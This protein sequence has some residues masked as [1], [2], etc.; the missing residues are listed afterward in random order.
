MASDTNRSSGGR[1]EEI[2]RLRRLVKELLENQDRLER[3]IHDLKRRIGSREPVPV[4]LGAEETS[5]F[6]INGQIEGPS[7]ALPDSKHGLEDLS[8]FRSLFRGREDVF[9]RMWRNAKGRTGYSPACNNEWVEGLCRKGEVKCADCPHRELTPLTD[10]VLLDHLRGKQVIGVYPLLPSGE[11]FFLA[12]D[13]D[14]A[15]WQED[16]S[17]FLAACGEHGIVPAV[18]RSRSGEGGHVWIFFE[19]AV[20]AVKARR[21]GSLLLTEAMSR[22]YEISMSTYDRF[23]PNQ[24]LMPKGGFG[25]LIALPLQRTSLVKGNT[26]FLDNS[27]KPFPDQWRYLGSISRVGRQALDDLAGELTG[28]SKSMGVCSRFAE[29]KDKPWLTVPSK[30]FLPPPLK[31]PLPK[32]VKATLGN[33]VYVEKEG[34]PASLL[35]RIRRLAA[36]QNPEFYKKQNLRLST[37]LTPRM[38]CCAEDFPDHV[39]I[40]R[41]CLGDLQLLLTGAGIQLSIKD[42]RFM[43]TPI[44]AHFVGELDKEQESAVKDLLMH[45]TGV[46]VAPPGR[47]KTLMAIKAVTSRSTNTLILVHRR[48]LMEQWQE[49]LTDFLEVAPETIGQIGG[50]REKRTGLIDIGM[51]QSLVRKGVVKDLVTE[52]GLVIMDECHHV[53]AVSFERALREVKARYV[54]GLTATPQRRDGHHPIVLMQCGPVRHMAEREGGDRDRPGLAKRLI[55]RETGFR[56]APREGDL[57]I[58]EVYSELVTDDIRNRMI[59]DDLVA[60]VREGRCPLLLTERRQHLETLVNTIDDLVENLIVL[61]GGLTPKQRR[62]A[63]EKLASVPSGESR[64]IAAT[65]RLIGEGFDD[66]RLDTLFL[67]MPFADRNTLVQ[68]SGRLERTHPGKTQIRIYDYVDTN[69]GMLRRMFE[70][71]MRGYKSIGYK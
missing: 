57:R 49:R 47:G 10:E 22:R 1:D 44:E 45:D 64:V 14:G 66:A 71:R 58:Q 70:K 2:H 3:E 41:G 25:N 29:D 52:Y 27:F 36:F 18:E 37:A 15:G 63:M 39:G 32:T 31:G 43:G 7:N 59:V 35:D 28:R 69:V 40:P 4:P 46:L 61:H 5:S 42:E 53:P 48:P 50:G 23:F 30:R 68:Y 65:G 8:L 54:Y 33:L 56:L 26:C 20:K 16:A 6:S 19:R 67:A 9:A 51:L 38:I 13:F 60:S 21:L 24:D 55:V 17:E 34:L 62:A 12:V 11:C